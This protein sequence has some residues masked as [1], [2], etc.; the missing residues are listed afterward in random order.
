MM[1]S[2]INSLINAIFHSSAPCSAPARRS[3][4]SLNKQACSPLMAFELAIPFTCNIF[5]K[6]THPSLLSNLFLK[7]TSVRLSLIPTYMLLSS[8]SYSSPHSTYQYVKQKNFY[9]FILFIVCSVLLECK[10]HEGKDFYQYFSLA[11][12]VTTG[13]MFGI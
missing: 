6:L 13:N 4:C 9:L 8:L 7:V 11:V 12:S 3:T 1:L 2:R 5:S 10:L